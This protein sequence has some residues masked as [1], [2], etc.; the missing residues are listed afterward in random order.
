MPA[1]WTDPPTFTYDQLVDET[2][3]NTYLRDNLLWLK[4]DPLISWTSATSPVY[5]GLD[6]DVVVLTLGS[7]LIPADTGAVYCEA[8]AYQLNTASHTSYST[9][10]AA[11][12][13]SVDSTTIAQ[14][15]VVVGG[16]S[17][18]IGAPLYLRSREYNWSGLTKTIYLRL[19]GTNCSAQ[20][21]GTAALPIVLRIV[22]SF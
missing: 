4:S 20:I 12:Y 9:N 22:R 13:I 17:P 5:S 21:Q 10:S 15:N 18:S 6:G 1:D 16:I 8:W 2:D 7:L 11:A 19:A 3:L 14:G